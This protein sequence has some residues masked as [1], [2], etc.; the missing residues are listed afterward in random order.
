MHQYLNQ[1]FQFKRRTNGG[2]MVGDFSSRN[3]KTMI[4]LSCN[5][6][7]MIGRELRETILEISM[8]LVNKLSGV[9]FDPM[10]T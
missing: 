9:I 7:D 10:I 6:I 4:T 1:H 8:D 2:S 5:L 3:S